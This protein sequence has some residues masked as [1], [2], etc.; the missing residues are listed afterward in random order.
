[1]P[2]DTLLC[3]K[4]GSA[5]AVSVGEY[6][7]W[8]RHPDCGWSKK[9]GFIRQRL[10]ERFIEP[11]SNTPINA[12]HGFATMAVSCLL[13]ET[14]EAF[15][16]GWTSTRTHSAE[17]FRTFFARQPRFAEFNGIDPPDEFYESVRCGLLHQGETRNGW[18]ITRTG[19]VLDG[20]RI[21]ATRFHAR[22]AGAINDYR[23]ELADPNC[24]DLRR[25]FDDKMKFIIKQAQ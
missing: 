23:D 4:R 11:I 17:S 7:A 21:N 13:I 24:T 9:P 16:Q 25:K 5:N 14:L 10:R 19:L 20:K 2:E 18:T 22:L 3:G 8:N 15:R 6:K 12:R 1:M